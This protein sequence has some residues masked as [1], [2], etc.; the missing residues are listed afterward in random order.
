MRQLITL[1]LF[2]PVLALAQSAYDA[3]IDAYRGHAFPCDGFV[4]PVLRIQNMG[5]ITMATCVV[6]TW[7]NGVMNNS[8][9]W[10]LAVP[11]ASGEFRQPAFPSVPVAPGDELE[12]RIISVNGQPDEG[13]TGNILTKEVAASPLAATG[14]HVLVE[15]MTDDNPGE[16]TWIIRRVDGTIA[17]QGGP[18]ADAN[19]LQSVQVALVA[20][21]CHQFELYDSGGDGISAGSRGPGYARVKNLGATLVDI[22]GNSFTDRADGGMKTGSD[23]CTLTGLTTTASPEVSCGVT[24]I[25]LNGSRHLYADEVPGATKYQFRFTNAPGQ[26]T[27]A[28]NIAVATNALQMVRWATQ[29]LKRGRTYNVQ[30]RASLDGGVTWCPFGESCTVKIAT[31]PWP[32]F[33]DLEQELEQEPALVLFPVPSPDGTFSIRFT[34]M[35]GTGEAVVLEVYDPMGRLAFSRSLVMDGLN[36]TAINPDQV[37]P[38][39]VYLVRAQLGDE[40]LT[41]RL[42]VQ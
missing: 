40:I 18:Y 6:E 8:F 27:Y 9:N 42:L 1:F 21:A 39:G 12:F 15:I 11:A 25:L 4:T 37:L 10:I 3:R 32:G 33:R 30:V 7:K 22:P 36:T 23:P 5:S 34:G 41:Q 2:A 31:H 14:F 24:D 28:R 13:A 16:I 17:A 20:G 35:A 19:A 29:P 26:P 38:P